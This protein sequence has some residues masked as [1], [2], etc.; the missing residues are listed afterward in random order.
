MSGPIIKVRV[1][2]L[3]EVGQAFDELSKA[4]ARNVAKR[5]LIQ[6]AQPMVEMASRLAP[7]NPE[8][9]APDLHS[10]IVASAKIKNT[11]GNAEFAAVMAAGGTKGE[12]IGALRDARRASAGEG[13]FAQAYVGP[14]SSTKRRAIKAIVQEF[15]SVKQSPRPYM[16]PAFAATAQQVI[17]GVGAILKVEIGKA[18]ARAQARALKKAMT[19]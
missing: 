3:R 14:V 4:T 13:S 7:D 12:A 2:G 17:S 1:E 5:A 10:S 6:A 19:K 16:R 8:T 9:G 15:G 11:V 18:V